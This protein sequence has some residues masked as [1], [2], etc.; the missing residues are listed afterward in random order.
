MK[1][2]KSIKMFNHGFTY[3]GH[4]ASCAA[5]LA[6]LAIY[7]EQDT[8]KY[9]STEVGPHWAD[10]WAARAECVFHSSPSHAPSSGRCCRGA[11]G[12]G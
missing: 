7:N 9:V 12:R 11:S 3:S 6:T 5:G 10:R 8:P 1:I 4:P 2:E